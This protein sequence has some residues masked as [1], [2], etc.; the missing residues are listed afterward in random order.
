SASDDEQ[1][2]F[3]NANYWRVFAVFREAFSASE[4]AFRSKGL[5]TYM[6]KRVCAWEFA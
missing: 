5:L 6:R 4:A 3:F 2:I 1:H